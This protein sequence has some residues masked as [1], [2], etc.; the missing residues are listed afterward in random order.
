M[1][2]NA[3]RLGER[4]GLGAPQHGLPQAGRGRGGTAASPPTDISLSRLLCA[5]YPDVERMLL[6]AF[7]IMKCIFVEFACLLFIAP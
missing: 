4:G 5:V 7:V 3:R 6:F 2:D 1:S